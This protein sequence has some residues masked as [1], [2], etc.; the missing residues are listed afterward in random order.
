MPATLYQART[1]AYTSEQNK[2]YYEIELWLSYLV[3]DLDLDLVNINKIPFWVRATHV[4][5]PVLL[6]NKGQAT[7]QVHNTRS[8]ITLRLVG[9]EGWS[10]HQAGRANKASPTP[11]SMVMHL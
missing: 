2:V 6:K 11:W 9:W 5:V 8:V 1:S 3:L 10:G 4:M 7:S